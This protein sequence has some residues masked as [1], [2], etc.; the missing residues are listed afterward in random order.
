M[1]KDLGKS[2]ASAL[3]DAGLQHG[4]TKSF[5]DTLAGIRFRGHTLIWGAEVDFN[6]PAGYTT[7]RVRSC[8]DQ[9]KKLDI[10]DTY[11][12]ASVLEAITNGLPVRAV[13]R[14]DY[15]SEHRPLRDCEVFVK[16]RV[17]W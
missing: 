15:K 2:L 9:L 10:S 5:V 11:M 12:Q 14:V 8:P 17:P 4:T 16:P 6:A 3:L 7:F 13:V 1:I